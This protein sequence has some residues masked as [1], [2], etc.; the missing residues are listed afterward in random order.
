MVLVAPTLCDAI[1]VEG[2]SLLLFGAVG[3]LLVSLFF[4][5]FVTSNDGV[6]QCGSGFIS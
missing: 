1:C 2:E 3:Y 4:T 6:A 5:G